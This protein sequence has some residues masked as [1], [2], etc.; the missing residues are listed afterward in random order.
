MHEMNGYVEVQRHLIC[1]RLY[2][3]I[4]VCTYMYLL[5][6]SECVLASNVGSKI[7]K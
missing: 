6:V 7:A 2:D 3:T 1:T 5:S 4:L